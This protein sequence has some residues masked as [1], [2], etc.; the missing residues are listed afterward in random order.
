MSRALTSLLL[1]FCAGFLA[2]KTTEQ[3]EFGFAKS[4]ENPNFVLYKA[5][6]LG[7]PTKTRS[8]P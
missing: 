3:F 4:L 2:A 8:V 7:T 5:N 1:L 6:E